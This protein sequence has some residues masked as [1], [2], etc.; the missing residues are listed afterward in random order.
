MSKSVEGSFIALSD[1]LEDIQSKLAKAPT[2]AGGPGDHNNASQSVQNLFKFLYL[3][4]PE[5]HGHF[6]SL[7][8]DGK[9]RYK[10]MKDE[11]SQ[12]IFAE[13]QP[14]Q[15][16]RALL[17]NEYVDKVIAEGAKKAQK[18]AAETIK[19]VKEKMGLL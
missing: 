19:E 8:R 5:R 15:E 14:L 4:L 11:L 17:T 10:D 12:A 7:Y 13:I 6:V 3:F 16:R 18:V 9:L 2:D 1:S